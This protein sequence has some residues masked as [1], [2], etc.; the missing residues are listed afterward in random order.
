MTA[1]VIKRTYLPTA[2]TGQMTGTPRPYSTVE[3]A[4]ADNAPDKSC[5]PEGT[6]DL[7]PYN[8]PTHGPTWY[9]QNSDLG[10]GGA[11]AARSFCE[12]HAANF[13]RQLLG[14]IAA[15]LEGAPMLDAATGQVSPA[16][17]DS[18]PA[19][20][21]LLEDLGAM[22]VGHTLTITSDAGPP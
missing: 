15:G 12:L 16:V 4:W 9:L 21:Q 6:Y 20:A 13:A 10:V 17:E 3:L 2:T 18:R 11:G 19:I 22:S 5:V 8:S 14:C 1:L 7:I